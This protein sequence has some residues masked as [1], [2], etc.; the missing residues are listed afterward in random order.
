LTGARLH[1]LA[2]HRGAVASLAF[3][4]D[5]RLLASGSNDTTVLLWDATSLRRG[6]PPGGVAAGTADLEARWAN[7]NRADAAR[8]YRSMRELL[9]TPRPTVALLEKRL[10][11]DLVEPKR[12]A[13]LLA[14]LDSDDFATREKASREL[15][16]LGTAAE[17]ALRRALADRPSL[18]LQ[19][20]IEGLLRGL[21]GQHIGVLRGV[22]VLEHVNTTEARKLL[23]ALARG[24]PEARLTR[25]A[26]EALG[27]LSRRAPS[28]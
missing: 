5:G 10:R 13:K 6:A 11:L 28:R 8:A 26:K 9:A 16:G 18:E 19:H 24:E 12:A 17:P 21:E 25:E 22:E 20:R 15:A 14:D 7:L 4:P 2:G 27:R 1:T 3:S 23:A